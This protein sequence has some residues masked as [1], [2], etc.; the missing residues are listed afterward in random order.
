MLWKPTHFWNRL[1]LNDFILGSVELGRSFGRRRGTVSVGT[2]LAI[3]GMMRWGVCN[4]AS[5]SV[6]RYG[7]YARWDNGSVGRIV[8]SVGEDGKLCLRES[9][10][11]TIIS[12]SI[13]S[14]HGMCI[15]RQT[16]ENGSGVL[17]EGGT[18][19]GIMDGSGGGGSWARTLV[20][21][22]SREQQCGGVAEPQILCPPCCLI[23][24]AE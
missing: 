18:S 9:E 13:S 19:G 10:E 20:A 21:N 12:F 11:L 1:T 22:A 3:S 17:F 14:R 23:V 24:T 6:G 5:R 8:Q 2:R 15:E 7:V 16:G 4:V